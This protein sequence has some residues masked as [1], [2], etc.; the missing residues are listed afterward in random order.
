M[1]YTIDLTGTPKQMGEMHGEQF[2]TQIKELAEIRKHLISTFL[3]DFK[4]QE[5]R[6]LC[7]KQILF[8]KQY[9]DLYLELEGISRS[10]GTTLEDLII[11]NNYTDMRDFTRNSLLS[12]SDEGCSVVGVKS[13][14]NFFVGQTWDMHASAED[15]TLHMKIGGDHVL[16]LVGCLGLAGVNQK[17]VSVLIN[18]LHCKETKIGLIWPALVRLILKANNAKEAIQS[19]THHLPCSGHN[20]LISDS[21]MMANFETTG[22]R[23]IKTNDISSEGIIYHTNH[24]TSDLKETENAARRSKTTDIRYSA[25]KNYFEKNDYSSFQFKNL[26]EDLL[27]G[28]VANAVCI[29]RPSKERPHDPSTCGGIAFDLKNRKGVLFKGLFFDGEVKEISW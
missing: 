9:D 28:K 12:F 25:I 27:G 7:Q 14:N 2:K 24:Y 10:S 21:E 17:N 22:K 13:K 3:T 15:Y 11:L 20:Y 4:S 16:S 5:I 8:L 18:N 6:E 19:L 23:F 29:A 1:I 26:T